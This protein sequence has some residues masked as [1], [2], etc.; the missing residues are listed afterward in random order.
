PGRRARRRCCAAH[1][2]VGGVILTVIWLLPAV[3]AVAAAFTPARL[4]KLVGALFAVATLGLTLV[5][6][7]AFDSGHHGYQFEQNVAWIRQFGVSYHLGVDGISLW[8]VVLNA[9]LTVIA[10]LA[11][12]G[13]TRRIS[14]FV[15]M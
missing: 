6:A 9:F 1:L 4:A 2:P 8:L 13:Q 3:G 14:A 15:S 11:T 5:V 12:S 10:I 7:L